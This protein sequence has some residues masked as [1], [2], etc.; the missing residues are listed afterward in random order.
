MELQVS[1][2]SMARMI[3]KI[4]QSSRQPLK[5]MICFS[6]I[7]ALPTGTSFQVQGKMKGTITVLYDEG[8]DLFNITVSPD[9]PHQQPIIQE[10]V[11]SDMLVSTINAAI[12]ESD[13]SG[14]HT[15]AAS[16]LP[17]QRIAV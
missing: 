17:P 14:E 9:N 10:D 7:T 8:K 16:R 15:Y 1:D 2:N 11:F 6:T 5:W 13:N 4:L 3:W 12:M